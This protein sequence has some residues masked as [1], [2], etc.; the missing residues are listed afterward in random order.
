MKFCKITSFDSIILIITLHWSFIGIHRS[1]WIWTKQVIS[2]KNLEALKI[3][4]NHMIRSWKPHGYS[5]LPT[6]MWMSCYNEIIT[7]VSGL[8]TLLVVST[9]AIG[10]GIIKTKQHS[11][12]RQKTY[13]LF[14]LETPLLQ[15]SSD[16]TTSD[17]NSSMKIQQTVEL[18]ETKF[19]PYYG[20]RK[21]SLH[22]NRWSM[23]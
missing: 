7:S 9:R 2:P 4:Q 5:Y 1:T 3:I 17:I 21:A 10:S 18:V 19:K 15:V 14:C 11:L 8:P 16:I 20:G 12:N 6:R 22:H 13:P 23:L